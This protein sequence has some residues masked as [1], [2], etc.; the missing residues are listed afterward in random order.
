MKAQGLLGFA[1]AFKLVEMGV[2]TPCYVRTL[3]KILWYSTRIFALLLT[4]N[5]KATP[6]AVEQM[7]KPTRQTKRNNKGKGKEEATTHNRQSWGFSCGWEENGVVVT[8]LDG[9]PLVVF[10]TLVLCVGRP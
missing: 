9:F 6:T 3:A 7:K 8:T 1:G 2:A 10:L 5:E 4:V